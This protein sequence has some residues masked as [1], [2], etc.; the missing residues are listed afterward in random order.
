MI[1]NGKLAIVSGDKDSCVV[2]MTREDYN[3]KLE[4]ILNDGVS[5]DIYAVKTY[6]IYI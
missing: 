5:K 3:N 4:A 2:V 1:N 6:I